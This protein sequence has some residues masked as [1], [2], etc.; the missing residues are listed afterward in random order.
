MAVPSPATLRLCAEQLR[1]LA[2]TQEQNAQHCDDLLSGVLAL[3]N[4]DTWTGPYPTAADAE[5]GRWKS[6]LRAS[7]DELRG[8]AAQWRQTARHFDDLADAGA[9][10]GAAS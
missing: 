9:A 10:T 6:G 7:A 3:A 4:P 5:F 1:T 2:A 8:E